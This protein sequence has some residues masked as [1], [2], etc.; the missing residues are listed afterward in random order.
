MARRPVF[1]SPGNHDWLAA[2]SPYLT[3]DWPANVT[4]F[5]ERALS[6]LELT[7]GLVLWGAAHQT[8]R[9][10]SNLFAGVRGASGATNL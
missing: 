7:H 9:G 2:S 8:P 1:V 6:P 5:R 4:I 3:V 10:T